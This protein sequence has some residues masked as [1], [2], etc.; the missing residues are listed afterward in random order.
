MIMGLFSGMTA[1]GSTEM[2][3]GFIELKVVTKKQETP[4]ETPQL[5]EV[6]VQS[7]NTDLTQAEKQTAEKAGD[8]KQDIAP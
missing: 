5:E 2:L 4:K 1:V 6:P 7:E 8:T 3:K